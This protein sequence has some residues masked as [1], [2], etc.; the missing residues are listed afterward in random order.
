MPSD[1]ASAT[2]LLGAVMEIALDLAARVV[3][4]TMRARDLSSLIR[5][6]LIARCR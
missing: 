3:A 5:A 2:R 4:W 1:N 6:R